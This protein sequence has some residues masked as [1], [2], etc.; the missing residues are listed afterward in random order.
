[1]LTLQFT[2]EGLEFS[3]QKIHLAD[4]FFPVREVQRNLAETVRN[5]KVGIPT[6]V[7]LAILLTL[8]AMTVDRSFKSGHPLF[9]I[10][11]AAMMKHFHTFTS[12]EVGHYNVIVISLE[13]WQGRE[14]SVRIR[15]VVQIRFNL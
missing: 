7:A 14:Y 6:G 9:P 1:M 8:V 12:V 13:W 2:A 11:E 4:R 10:E 3:N 5:G 15:Q